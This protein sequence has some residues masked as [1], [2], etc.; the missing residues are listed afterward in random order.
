M[1]KN[2]KFRKFSRNFEPVGKLT[3]CNIFMAKPLDLLLSLTDF[4]EKSL[5]DSPTTFDR[6]FQNR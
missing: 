6:M 3:N 1:T 4:S 2:L 5:L